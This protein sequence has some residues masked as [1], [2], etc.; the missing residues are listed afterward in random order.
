LRAPA[1]FLMRS[2]KDKKEKPRR[3]R[4]F[5]NQNN[6]YRHSFYGAENFYKGRWWRHRISLSLLLLYAAGRLNSAFFIENWV[7]IW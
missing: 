6:F 7:T 2:R 1:L 4:A 3:G 5:P